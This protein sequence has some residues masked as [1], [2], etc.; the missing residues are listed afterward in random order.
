MTRAIGGVILI[1]VILGM[2]ILGLLVGLRGWPKML[3]LLCPLPSAG[4][5]VLSLEAAATNDTAKF[6]AWIYGAFAALTV[7]LE[8]TGYIVGKHRVAPR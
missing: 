3:Y 5:A 7:I 6:F 1:S 8:L 2:P 4:I